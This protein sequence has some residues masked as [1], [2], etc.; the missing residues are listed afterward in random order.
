MAEELKNQDVN[1]EVKDQETQENTTP[2]TPAEEEKKD[3]PK[4]EGV[5]SK[6]KRFGSEKV[7]PAVKATGKVV[8]KMAIITGGVLGAAATIGFVAGMTV[9]NQNEDAE[10]EDEDDN[11]EESASGGDEEIDELLDKDTEDE[12]SEDE[13]AEE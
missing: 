6:L 11:N 2:E 4:K 7:V 12:D 13:A 8:G 5:L 10:D 3:E 9:K 1:E